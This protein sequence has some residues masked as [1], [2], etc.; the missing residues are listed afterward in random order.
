MENVTLVKRSTD[1]KD[2]AAGWHKW[3][4]IATCPTCGKRYSTTL[5]GTRE[6]AEN[7]NGECEA[8]DDME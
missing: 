1:W 3:K 5:S 8:C 6:A 2:R 4:G 7:F